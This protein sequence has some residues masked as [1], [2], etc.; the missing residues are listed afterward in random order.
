MTPK[1]GQTV[2]CTAKNRLKSATLTLVKKINFPAGAPD[3]AK[4]ATEKDWNLKANNGTTSIEGTSGDS[5]VTN[6]KIQPGDYTLSETAKSAGITGGLPAT[7]YAESWK[8]LDA[9]GARVDKNSTGAFP[10][11]AGDYEI[12]RASCRERV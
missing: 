11:A 1:P 6:Q 9:A 12:G 8:C 7:A 2:T 10:F 5:A 3:W 4:K